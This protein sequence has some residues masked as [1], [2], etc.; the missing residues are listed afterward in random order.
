MKKLI[1][2]ATLF[3]AIVATL[4]FLAK[5]TFASVYDNWKGIL[6]GRN[7]TVEGHNYKDAEGK[8]IL[9]YR[10]GQK[11]YIVNLSAKG[12]KP[13]TT[14]QVKFYIGES[15]SAD[16]I[17]QPVGEFVAD[18]D[19]YG[20][21]NVRGFTPEEANFDKYETPSRFL[22][23]SGAWRVM[24]TYSDATEGGGEDIEPVGSN[25]GE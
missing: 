8:V 15:G 5:P 22:V 12:L 21:L 19:G 16:L 6:G 24:T 9:N 4:G 7:R 25:R 10:K 3:L 11:D 13:G 17:K 23:K 14:Y 20:H 18:V 1:T 2:K